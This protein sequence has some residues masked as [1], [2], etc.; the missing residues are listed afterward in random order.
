M[1]CCF[2]C[3]ANGYG[4]VRFCIVLNSVQYSTVQHRQYNTYKS[5]Q[6]R[7]VHTVQY[8]AIQ[9]SAVFAQC[10]TVLNAVHCDYG[11]V[12]FCLFCTVLSHYS[13]VQHSTI[14]YSTIQYSTMNTVQYSTLHYSTVQYNIVQ[15]KSA[16]C[17][18]VLN[19]VHCDYGEVG[20]CLFCTALSHYSPVQHN[21]R[22]Y[23]TI[24]YSTLQYSTVQYNIVQFKNAQCNI[25]LNAVH[26]GY[27]S[28]G[29][30]MFCAVLYCAVLHFLYLVHCRIRCARLRNTKQYCPA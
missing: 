11:A 9:Y 5:V 6:H 13:P 3:S 7:T 1:Q 12:G 28:V 29:F 24:Q 21:T 10:N 17:N 19:A 26:C 14:Q 20:F 23:S 18:T 27:G 4:T 22:Q 25:V 30:C 2:Q 15:F 8:S 16:Q